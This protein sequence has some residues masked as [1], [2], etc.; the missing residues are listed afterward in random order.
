MLCVRSLGCVFAELLLGSPVFPGDSGVGQLIEIIKVLGSPSKEEVIA[1]NPQHTTFKFPQIKAQVWNK[2]FRGKVPATAID[3]VSQWLCYDPVK[4]TKPLESLAH[5]FFDELREVNC[6]L[7]NG[8]D[9]P[10]SLFN[11]TEAEIAYAEAVGLKEKLMP[12]HTLEL[13][14]KLKQ[15]QQQQQQQQNKIVQAPQPPQQPFSQQPQ[16]YQ[17]E[18]KAATT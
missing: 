3:L 1:M 17:T 9:L 14:A 13:A 16:S 12:Q 15:Q 8:K 5:P 18:A 10:T 4:R 6:K 7:P 2:V 11:W